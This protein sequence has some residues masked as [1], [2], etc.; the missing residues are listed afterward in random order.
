MSL[1]VYIQKGWFLIPKMKYK[2][3]TFPLFSSYKNDILPGCLAS[4]QPDCSTFPGPSWHTTDQSLD[5]L[6]TNSFA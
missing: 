3:T 2:D 4:C 1:F 5:A 6:K